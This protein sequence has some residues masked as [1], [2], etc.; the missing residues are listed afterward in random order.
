MTLLML[1]L[2]LA[3][4][5][6]APSGDAPSEPPA[7][8]EPD[9]AQAKKLYENGARL[10]EEAL[11]EEAITA[12]QESYRLSNQ[13]ALLFNIANAQE[14]LGDLEGA[15]K[16]LN[17]YRIYA[18]EAEAAKLDRRVRT[19]EGRM[20]QQS[21]VP[22][23]DPTPVPVVTPPAPVTPVQK[24][25]TV[26]WVAI[27]G[28]LG[29]SAL[30]GGIA[31]LSYLNGQGAIDDGNE[32]TYNTARGLNNASI[33]VA[34]AGL[35]VAIVGLALPSKRTVQPLSLSISS[36]AAHVTASGRF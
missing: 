29:A 20:D 32:S 6:P 12:F 36:D 16:S 30:F 7:S 1:G 5:A 13:H 15:I 9:L 28:G 11:Y 10:Y 25:N 27:G 18:D 31:G 8:Q 17:T 2:A 14:R 19:L 4:D 3:Q 24:S 26:K 22:A 33:G 35:G 34:G 21:T 23:P